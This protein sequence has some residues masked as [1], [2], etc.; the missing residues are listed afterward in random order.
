MLE[1]FGQKFRTDLDLWLCEECGAPMQ[2]DGRRFHLLM[3]CV[4]RDLDEL[5]ERIRVQME[6]HVRRMNEDF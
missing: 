3:N 2:I 5:R 4:C 6:E 1:N